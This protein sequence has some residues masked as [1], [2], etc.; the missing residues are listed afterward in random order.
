MSDVVPFSRYQPLVDDWEQFQ[1][2]IR[3]PL[4]TTIWGHPDRISPP[5]LHALL[6]ASGVAPQPV[7]GF[8]G[9]FNLPAAWQPGLHWGYLAGLFHVQELVSL[10]PV[11]L[12]DPQPGERVLDMCAAPG[13]K[14]AQI[15]LRM[16]NRGTIVANDRS[17]G[18]MRAARQT[19]NRLG[20]VNVTMLTHDAANLPGALGQFDRILVDV[21][22][23][24]EGTCR[25]DPSVL[26]RV[27]VADSRRLMGKQ[28]AML[29]KAVQLCKPGGRIV[30]ATCTFAPEENE[31][32]VD[33]VLRALPGQVRLLPAALPGL[34][35]ETGITT[36]DGV[37]LDP[38]LAQ[39]V[40]VW[41]HHNDSGGFF[42]A[43]LEKVGGETTPSPPTVVEAY[44]DRLE[45]AEWVPI[46]VER[47]GLPAD[48]FADYV[49][50]RWS[51]RGAY[52]INRG[53]LAAPRPK[54][55]SVG[56]L[57]MRA[58]SKFPK[59]TTAVAL[60]LGPLATRN[61]VDLEPEQAA[62]YFRRGTF[63]LSTAQQTQCAGSG[64]VLLRYQEQHIGVG[65]FRQ[66]A[67]TV[68][69][70]FPKG[71]ARDSVVL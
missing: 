64:Y 38:S 60:L 9:V 3:R 40:R 30:Y 33:A 65:L 22:C 21:P 19:L 17:A 37:D 12:L 47:F 23:S 55:D 7:D 16:G 44:A 4:P 25:K 32:V 54:A 46:A 29:R 63:A 48:W 2:V 51:K 14:T 10:L 58:D 36:W 18:R 69:S 49:V 11:Q 42:I 52:L 39:A 35:T 57:F 8:P 31:M 43:V 70:M 6:T 5:H 66:G 67:Q 56:M 27:T 41:P 34:Q 71:W 53:H 45:T 1:G 20:V 59:V 15:G 13:N 61:V 24:C 68:E 62:L 28:G 26:D 50:H